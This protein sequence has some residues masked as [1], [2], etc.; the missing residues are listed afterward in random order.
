MPKAGKTGPEYGPQDAIAGRHF[1][2]AAEMQSQTMTLCTGVLSK[3]Y[4]F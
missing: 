1:F 2:I 4:G 3:S